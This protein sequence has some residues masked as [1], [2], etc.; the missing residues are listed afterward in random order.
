MKK[1]LIAALIVV[2]MLT[3]FVGTVSAAPLAT[4]VITLVSV[5][6]EGGTPVFIFNVSGELSKAELNGS[7]HIEGGEDLGLYCTQIDSNTIRCTTARAAAGKNVVIFLAG[8]VFWASVPAAFT[9]YCYD[10]YDWNPPPPPFDTWVSVG[11]YCQDIPAQN[12]DVINFY[13]P[14]WGQSYD[15]QFMPQSPDSDPACATSPL[16][17]S[18]Y[19]FPSCPF[20]EGPLPL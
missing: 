11:T 2:A 16:I 3:M 17:G 6:Y 10:V 1:S 5:E 18:A 14:D 20:V 15:Y 12:G 13:N 4:G 9:H 19:Y 7:L 8:Q